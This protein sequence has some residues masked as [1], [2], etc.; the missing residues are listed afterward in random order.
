MKKTLVILLG[1]FLLA[2]PVLAKPSRQQAVEILKKL[3][4]ALEAKDYGAARDLVKLPAAWTEDQ[5]QKALETAVP[6]GEISSA[7]VKIMA[8]KAK[9]LPAAD[10]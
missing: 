10:D 5:V 2:Q 8:R 1:L 9:W 6:N 3:A 4:K 7:A